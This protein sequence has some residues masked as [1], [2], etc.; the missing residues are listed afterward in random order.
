MTRLFRR[1]GTWIFLTGL[2][3]ALGFLVVHGRAPTVRTTQLRRTPLEQHVVVSGRVRVPMR[4]QIS[5]QIAGLVVAVGASAGQ[6]VETGD[7]LVQINDAELRAAAAQAKA[8]VDQ[9]RARV[10]QLKRVG[11]IAAT[12]ALREAETNL[13]GAEA[14]LAR[15]TDLAASGTLP[16]VELDNARR[17]VE[18]ARAQRTAA[19]AQQIASSELGADSRLALTA[20]LEAQARLAGAE[21][22]LAQSRIVAVQKGLLL[23]REVEPG[24]V[25]Q[26]GRTL[27]V[28]AADSEVELVFEAD[29]RNVALLELGQKASVAADAYPERVFAAKVSYIAPSI[30]PLRGSVEVRLVVEEPPDFL[31]PGMTVSVDLTVA[32]KKDAQVLP[33]EAVRAAMSPSPWVLVVEGGRVRRRPVKLGIRGNGATEVLSGLVAGAEV[34]LPNGHKLAEGQRVRPSREEP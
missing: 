22:R 19:E 7:L 2:V 23:T 12:Q 8:M 17:A 15:T 16:Q 20:L 28:M 26:P 3:V 27:M 9:A 5:A 29:E 32:S 14:E 4:V 30:D 13:E 31:K 21:A 10:D 25:V 1:P 18:R 11:R 6:R 24:D 34:A 33:S